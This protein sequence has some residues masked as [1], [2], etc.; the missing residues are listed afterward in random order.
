M[1]RRLKVLFVC[2]LNKQPRV[3]AER[4][5]CSDPRLEMRSAR[6]RAEARRRIKEMDLVWADIVFVMERT[7]KQRIIERFEDL[8]LPP[9]RLE[10]RA[11]VFGGFLCSHHSNPK[12]FASQVGR[13]VS[14]K[15]S[16]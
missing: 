2:A 8:E 6:V 1:N 7:H 10:L 3:T 11:R 15:L 14:A 4:L 16:H 9:G 12:G 5:Y 13:I